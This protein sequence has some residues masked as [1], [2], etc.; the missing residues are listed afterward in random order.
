MM[1]ITPI[2]VTIRELT[3]HYHDDG[4]NGVFAYDNRL[5][6]RPSF[7]REFV[8]SDSQRNAVIETVKNEFPLKNVFLFVLL[9]IVRS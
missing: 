8:Y 9:W 7:Q 1:K 5:T 3:E 4:D 2:T 6:V